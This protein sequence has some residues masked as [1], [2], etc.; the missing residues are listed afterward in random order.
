MPIS[1]RRSPT[2]VRRQ[3]D[4]CLG[5][6]ERG[7]SRLPRSGAVTVIP[8]TAPGNV[9]DATAGRPLHGCVF[10]AKCY[11]DL[12]ESTRDEIRRDLPQVSWL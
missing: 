3:R 4:C 5:Q 7:T 2:S 6:R 8:V 11:S 9:D 12:V 10:A 1:E